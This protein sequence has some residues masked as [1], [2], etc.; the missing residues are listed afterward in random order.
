MQR[1]EI[2]RNTVV[3]L[4]YVLRNAQ[5]DIFEY[6]DLPIEYLHGSGSDLFAKIEQSL[7]GRRV[8]DSVSVELTPDE[9]FGHHQPDL[10]FTDDLDNVPPEY[11]H[12][13]AKV[14]AQNAK[15]EVVI[16]VVTRIDNDKLTVD[17]NH[18]LAGQTVRFDVKVCAVRD[19]TADELRNGRPAGAPTTP[20]Q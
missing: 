19:A 7:E 2:G 14:E 11:R 18:P 13:G 16:F 9:G 1:D 6:S 3:A 15:G 5:G 10:T 4:T 8:G 20:I 17:A 12:V